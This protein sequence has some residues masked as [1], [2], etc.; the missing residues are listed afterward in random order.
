MAK[1]G[2]WFVYSC[3]TYNLCVCLHTSASAQQRLTGHSEFIK[4]MRL[5]LQKPGMMMHFWKPRFLHQWVIC[6]Q[7][8]VLLQI[9]YELILGLCDNRNSHITIDNAAWYHDYHN[10][11]PIA[12]C[13]HEIYQNTIKCSHCILHNMPSTIPSA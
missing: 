13:M 3:M 10:S 7:S 12:L 6:T 2:K 4:Y 5:D 8:L 1:F 11:W 9:V